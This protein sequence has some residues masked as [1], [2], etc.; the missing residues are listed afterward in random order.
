MVRVRFAPSPTGFL[1][2]GAARTAIYNWLYA[3][4]QNGTFILRIEDT[5][6]V[7]SSQ[8]MVQGIIDGM[9]WLGLDWDEGPIYQS[10]RLELYRERAKQLLQKGKAYYCYCTPEEIQERKTKTEAAGEYWWYDR[11]CYKLSEDEKSN[12]ESE[13]RAKAIRFI[14]PEGKTRYKDM[15]RGKIEVENQTIEDF[16]LL[17][18]DGHPTYHLSVVADDIDLGITH[19]IRGADHISNTPKQILLYLAF[20]AAVPRFAHQSLILGL[21][22]KKLSKRHGVTSVLQF[23]EDGFLS[24]ALLNYLVQMSWFPGEERIYSVTEMME[25]FYLDKR[26][27]GNPVFDMNKLEWLNGQL[28]SQTAAEELFPLVKSDFSRTGL[29]REEF[30]SSE[31]EW[32]LRL[33]DLLKE[34]SRKISDFSV[35]A[36]PFLSDDYPIEAEAAEKHLQDK[37]LNDLMPKLAEDFESLDSFKAEGIERILRQRAET[38][39][40]KAGLLIHACRVLVLGT[41]VSPG[42]F[43]VLELLGREKTVARLRRYE[44][45]CR[46]HCPNGPLQERE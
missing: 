1:H 2:V 16:V 32:F 45:I 34:R 43:E 11:R 13:G 12:F 15:I 18:S 23:Q 29:W 8:E 41:K 24:L 30:G 3:R 35:R 37:I 39:D 9:K 17:R 25:K 14:I 10:Q 33:L 26:S 31:K 6:V 38:E 42:I 4:N 21:D 28:I 46:D 44:E 22:K 5:D 19:V 27:G 36:I 7:R 20:G 40:I